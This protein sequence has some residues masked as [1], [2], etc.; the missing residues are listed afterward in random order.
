MTS[1]KVSGQSESENLGHVVINVTGSG[2]NNPIVM[3]WDRHE[4]DENATPPQSFV[5]DIP[6]GES[7]L[8]Q[9]LAVYG[10]DS[11]G[12]K[13]Y[14]GDAT[15]PIKNSIETVNLTVNAIGSGQQ[16]VSGTIQG[17]YLTSPDSGPSGRVLAKY[18]PPGKPG[19]II[20]KSYIVRGWF[21]L[22]ILDGDDS[23]RL[24]YE[25]EDGSLLWGRPV[26]MSDAEFTPS[27]T[28]L[29]VAMPTH[30]RKEHDSSD[31]SSEEAEQYAYGFFAAPGNPAL[32]AGKIA[33]SPS[34]GQLT[35]L[36]MIS[37]YASPTPLTPP[38]LPGLLL[39]SE[40][41]PTL[42]Q[43]TSVASPLANFQ[44]KGGQVTACPADISNSLDLGSLNSM[45][46]GNGK[47]G[48]SVHF[49][50]LKAQVVGNNNRAPIKVQKNFPAAGIF[51]LT[52]QF[53]PGVGTDLI[54]KIHIYK[55]VDPQ[56]W[57][58]QGDYLPC[59][60][61]QNGRFGFAKHAVLDRSTD[62]EFDLPISPTELSVGTSVGVCFGHGNQ[63]FDLGFLVEPHQF[64]GE[65]PVTVNNFEL[66]IAANP[67]VN[68][69][70]P[71]EVRLVNQQGSTVN[72][73]VTND[74]LQTFNLT[75]SPAVQIHDSLDNCISEGTQNASLSIPSGQN[76]GTRWIRDDNAETV[77]LSVQRTSTTPAQTNS[78]EIQV[79]SGTTPDMY[80]L[81]KSEVHLPNNGDCVEMVVYPALSTSPMN[82]QSLDETPT[83]SAVMLTTGSP[84]TPAPS[85]EL[86]KSC[87]D[88]TLENLDFDPAETSSKPGIRRFAIVRTGDTN[89][90][91]FRIK[92][93]SNNYIYVNVTPET[94]R[95]DLTF[96]NTEGPIYSGDCRQAN[97]V[98]KESDGS[99]TDVATAFPVNLISG[100]E[101]D[102]YTTA[103]CTT[104]LSGPI[105][106]PMGTSGF[107]ALYARFK[108]SGAIYPM[109]NSP[110][111]SVPGQPSLN[112]A[113]SPADWTDTKLH[114][115][116]SS[117]TPNSSPTFWYPSISGSDPFETAGTAV[118]VG[119]FPITDGLGFPVSNDYFVQSLASEMSA[120]FV[121][122]IRFKM[123]SL[124][125][126]TPESIVTISN[127]G[128]TPLS[129]AAWD[130]VTR[131]GGVGVTPVFT[132]GVWYNVA[133][134]RMSDASNQCFV[135][136]NGTLGLTT[137]CSDAVNKINIGGGANMQVKSVILYNGSPTASH[138]SDVNAYLNSR[139][140]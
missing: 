56:E 33:C 54:D 79:H 69:C 13:F 114:F 60:A 52:A 122:M 83:V 4:H 10:G 131:L 86:H 46:N 123:N 120:P 107:N 27:N 115:V 89:M 44:V 97:L 41:L 126:S 22:F 121:L 129:L 62:M 6:R 42:A 128:L 110:F 71:V 3:T 61:L 45:L 67:K 95:L 24:G 133:I 11:G 117:V 109:V 88:S 135:Y 138:L 139:F 124:H 87:T 12:M 85:F 90:N 127:G 15:Q 103:N 18:F 136:V 106:Y 102:W 63:L 35:G 16:I 38:A 34:A 9:V 82:A 75:A 70:V 36:S 105:S 43:L 29:R 80:M 137:T 23:A 50:P 93:G 68:M 91:D 57:R 28:V 8:I 76:V 140:P 37:Q 55:R 112:V 125:A 130:G 7:R 78:I 84:H 99:T 134:K 118:T 72:S 31:W 17:R 74:I 39:S 116:S 94:H 14:Y 2:I 104:L 51:R 30:L 96:S 65:G 111:V 1:K 53:L 20:E 64:S 40:P 108:K 19:L 25:L 92:I 48:A 81:S 66:R 26:K 5:L 98:A 32:V 100:A 132:T 58:P 77:T 113:W 47:E 59:Q 101:V 21:S 73:A 119:N 49:V